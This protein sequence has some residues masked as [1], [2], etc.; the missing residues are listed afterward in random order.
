[1]IGEIYDEDIAKST[2]LKSKKLSPPKEDKEDLKTLKTKLKT[3]QKENKKLQKQQNKPCDNCIALKQKIQELEQLN[4][5]LIKIKDKLN[6]S[7]EETTKKYK[8]LLKTNETLIQENQKLSKEI[9]NLEKE[10]ENYKTRKKNIKNNDMKTPDSNSDEDSN[11]ANSESKENQHKIKSNKK[12]PKNPEIINEIIERLKTLENWKNNITESDKQN[13]EKISLLEEKMSEIEYK[14]NN[15]EKNNEEED[16]EEN[17]EEENNENYNRKY[18]SKSM[19]KRNNS[20]IPTI[21]NMSNS[22]NLQNNMGREYISKSLNTN[23]ATNVSS[24]YKNSQ[25]NKEINNNKLEKT[26]QI[27]FNSKILTESEDLDLIALGLVLGNLEKLKC[28]KVG[29]KLLYRASEH[30]G[31]VKKFHDRCDGI[32]GTLTV[33]KTIED[34]VFGGYTTASWDSKNENK[35]SDLYSFVFSINLSKI[36]FVSKISDNSLLCDRKQGPCFIG[37]FHVNDNFLNECSYINPWNVQCYSG[38]SQK[39]EI[40]GGKNEFIVKELEVFQVFIK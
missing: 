28:L 14:K 15:N 35:K 2:Y 29:Y 38:E 19:N 13:T 40:N 36:Y 37:M 5:E 3:L 21:N 25:Y 18:I 7:N 6:Q 17:E 23:Y 22:S 39:Y 32:N 10:K 30:G 12:I 1:M 20:G 24:V 9:K 8:E 31:Y 33:I 4:T 16:E 26:P 11:S 27:K 34:N